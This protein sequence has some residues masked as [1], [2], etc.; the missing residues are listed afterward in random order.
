MEN[1]RKRFLLTYGTPLMYGVPLQTYSV[2]L[3]EK[4]QQRNYYQDNILYQW[5]LVST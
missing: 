1:N 5:M 4:N 2:T 3:A